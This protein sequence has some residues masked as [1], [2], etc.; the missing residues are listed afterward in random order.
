MT[1]SPTSLT[2][3]VFTFS[4]GPLGA[5]AADADNWTRWQLRHRWTGMPRRGFLCQIMPPVNIYPVADLEAWGWPYA[6]SGVTVHEGVA[7]A[8]HK[9]DTGALWYEVVEMRLNAEDYE[10]RLLLRRVPRWEWRSRQRL[11]R[12]LA[13]DA[14]LRPRPPD[15]PGAAESAAYFALVMARLLGLVRA[16]ATGGHHARPA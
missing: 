6:P 4:D 16:G 15:E 7:E 8:A 1:T 3:A 14:R 2:D 11:R 13:R 5:A 10:L 9:Y 12:Q